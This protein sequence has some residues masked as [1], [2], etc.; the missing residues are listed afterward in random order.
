MGFSLPKVNVLDTS[1]L[2]FS[3]IE[4]EIEAVCAYINYSK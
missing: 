3:F 2:M 4:N 1:L